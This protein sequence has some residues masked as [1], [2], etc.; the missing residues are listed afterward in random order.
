MELISYLKNWITDI[1]VMFVFITL[2]EIILPSSNMKKYID[3]IVGLLIIIVL[4]N[5]FIKIISKDIDIDKNIFSSMNK[6]NY[7]Y[8]EDT[9]FDLIKQEQIS[10][11][12]I[13]SIKGKVKDILKDNASYFVQDV[14]ITIEDN[15]NSN[16]YGTIK[17]M[18]LVLEEKVKEEKDK[19]DKND[20]IKIHNVEQ[21]I[22]ST[23]NSS[24]PEYR[25]FEDGD[26]I[27]KIISN[28][29]GLSTEDINIYLITKNGR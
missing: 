26:D 13:N 1:V 21:I 9:G 25:E 15:A 4:I 20:S 10:E 27:K 22:V 14:Q 16:E 29:F 7:E 23:T 3:M 17:K 2:L 6:F 19:N 5:P 12:Y 18:N 28:D 24:K 8:K 11:A